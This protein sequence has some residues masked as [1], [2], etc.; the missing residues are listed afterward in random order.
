[1]VATDSY[2][3]K[4]ISRIITTLYHWLYIHLRGMCTCLFTLFSLYAVSSGFTMAAVTHL[5]K[6]FTHLLA[7]V[8]CSFVIIIYI[9]TYTSEVTAILSIKPLYLQI[10]TVF[11]VLTWVVMSEDGVRWTA[12]NRVQVPHGPLCYE[13]ELF[14]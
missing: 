8:T 11:M 7:A 12:H 14:I 6:T 4:L 5:L 9:H 1:M 13:D 3:H 10:S 2:S